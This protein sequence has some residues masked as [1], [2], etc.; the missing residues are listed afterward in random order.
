MSAIVLKR[1]DHLQELFGSENIVF[2]LIVYLRWEPEV[3][4]S[5]ELIYDDLAIMLVEHLFN[6]F[7]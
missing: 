2:N 5:I 3:I 7:L 1:F 4:L 6:S